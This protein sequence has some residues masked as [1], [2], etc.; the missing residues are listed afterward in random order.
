MCCAFVVLIVLRFVYVVWMLRFVCVFFAFVIVCWFLCCLIP[1]YVSFV[2]CTSCV[3]CV[4]VVC[5]V[6]VLL[7]VYVCLLWFAHVVLKVSLLRVVF[8]FCLASMYMSFV[9]WTCCVTCVF[10]VCCV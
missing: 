3:K 4:F 8:L 5:C 6:L 1:L 7:Y 10:V 2:V 9:V